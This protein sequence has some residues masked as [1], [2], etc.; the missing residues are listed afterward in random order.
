MTKDLNKVFEENFKSYY[1]F[2]ISGIKYSEEQISNLS[3]EE[4]QELINSDGLSYTEV[5]PASEVLLKYK[6]R[7]TGNQKQILENW[8]NKTINKL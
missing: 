4:L 2:G 1:T 3:Q 6:D 7:L 8:T 5:L